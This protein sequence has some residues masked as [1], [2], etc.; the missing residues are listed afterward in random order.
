MRKTLFLSLLIFCSFA[1]SN[2]QNFQLKGLEIYNPVFTNPAFT[3]S[4]KLA[5][6]DVLAYDFLYYN[7]YQV[8]AMT[9]LP[10]TNSSFGLNL[11][12]GKSFS[13][14][15]YSGLDRSKEN[16]SLRFKSFD[17]SYAYDHS[18]TEHMHLSGGIS[19]SHGLL[20]FYGNTRNTNILSRNVG[21][22]NTGL[23]FSYRKLYAGI[24]AGTGLYSWKK[25]LNEAN[26][27][28]LTRDWTPT[29]SSNFIAGYSLGGERRVNFEPVIGFLYGK[30]FKT[31]NSNFEFYTG[32]NITIA[33]TVG[34]GFTVGDMYSL[35]TS[36][37][38]LDRVSLIV[39]V[40]QTE[41]LKYSSSGYSLGFDPIE[42]I[43]QIRIKF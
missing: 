16:I 37:T 9:R 39:G 29:F 36:I 21:S 22:L 34:L 13:S 6:I 7:G 10:N 20:K 32:A 17:I 28:V 2:A 42:Y 15:S 31:D 40:Y 4:D 27:T 8:H 41:D 18:F 26:E 14:Y 24:S 33:N 23:K 12:S 11:S 35:S 5:Q 30:N 1:I 43:A 38:I 25:E 19:L 3:S